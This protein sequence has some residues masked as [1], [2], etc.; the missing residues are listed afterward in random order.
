ME[1]HRGYSA[2]LIADYIIAKNRDP[3]HSIQVIKTAYI[4]HGYCLAMLGRP[5]I[6]EKAQAWR[7]GPVFPSMYFALR[8]NGQN[9]I[10][11]LEYCDTM[12]GSKEFDARLDFLKARIDDDRREILDDAIDVYGN[13]SGNHLISITHA[14]DTPWSRYYRPGV[15]NTVIPDEETKEYYKKKLRG[16]TTDSANWATSGSGRREY[17][18]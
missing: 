17:Q 9:P 2:A 3:M 12:H 15:F 4:A 10:Q 7:Y 1:R 16:R 6:R 18:A 14:G 8:D 5:L 11:S 13:L